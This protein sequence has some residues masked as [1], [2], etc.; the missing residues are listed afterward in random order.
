MIQAWLILICDEIIYHIYIYMCGCISHVYMH[1]TIFSW[2]RGCAT[3]PKGHDHALTLKL[4]PIEFEFLSAYK[5]KGAAYNSTAALIDHGPLGGVI[6][7]GLDR[8]QTQ[9]SRFDLTFSFSR[10]NSTPFAS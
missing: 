10:K 1:N 4:C 5:I 7:V 3:V 6:P 2:A 8:G 9:L